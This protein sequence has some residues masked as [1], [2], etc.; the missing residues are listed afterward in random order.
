MTDLLCP[1][2]Q[3]KGVRNANGSCPI[4]R[5][6]RECRRCGFVFRLPLEKGKR[7]YESDARKAWLTR[8][9]RYGP[10]GMRARAEVDEINLL[11]N[12]RSA[13]HD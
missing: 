5:N 9:M 12:P 6:G 8:K 2:C 7:N 3:E 11:P 13:D 10:T 1:A 4:L